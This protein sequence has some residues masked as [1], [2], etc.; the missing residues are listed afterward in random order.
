MHKLDIHSIAGL[1]RYAVRNS[2]VQA[3]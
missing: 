3:T 1:V 2:I